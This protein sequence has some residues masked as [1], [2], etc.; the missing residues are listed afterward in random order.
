[1]HCYLLTHPDK[2]LKKPT[3]M[4]NTKFFLALTFVLLSGIQFT[5]AACTPRPSVPDSAGLDPNWEQLPCIKRN[6]PYNQVIYVQN[7]GQVSSSVR[8]EWLEVNE[9][10]NVPDGLTA[11]FSY[12]A[13][14]P[15]RRLLSDET[16]CIE[17][18]GTTSFPKGDY[19]LGIVVCVK[20]NLFSNP[21][22]GPAD[23]L[24]AQL[25]NLVPNLPNF[26]FYLRVIEP[27]E[28]C[29]DTN[30]IGTPQSGGV[31]IVPTANAYSSVEELKS[32]NHLSIYPNPI[33]GKATI[34]FVS[35]KAE[36][37]KVRL[38]DLMGREVYADNIN[39]GAGN[40]H[41]ELNVNALP[42]GVYLLTMSDGAAAITRRVIIE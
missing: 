15:P 19:K 22:C 31:T 16:G 38:I 24:V 17:I 29:P 3:T 6:T 35:T 9:I 32:I 30:L 42:S 33:S 2:G 34:A 5:N 12:P 13:A 28:T 10:R 26:D 14:N 11:S 27:N 18:T 40:N 8:V 21:L 37:Y 7:F 23:S 20:I 25:S 36:T 4:K 1:L 39:T 41:Y